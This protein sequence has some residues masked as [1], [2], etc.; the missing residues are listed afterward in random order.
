VRFG[1]SDKIQ[2]ISTVK[3]LESIEECLPRP[4]KH[5]IP[6]WFKD[7]PSSNS[8]SIK[9]CPAL[10]DYFSQGYIIPMWCDVRMSVEKNGNWNWNTSVGKFSWTSHSNDQLINHTDAS[11][12]G[13]DGQFIFKA[14]SPWQI[15]TPPG[16]SVLQLPLFYHFNKEWSVLPGIIDTDIY[17]ETNQQV[18]YHA[19]GK[20][21]KI[22]RG[23][24]FVLYVPFKRSNKLKHSISYTT[25]KNKLKTDQ[26]KLEINTKF[27]P[28]GWYRNKQRKRDKG[29][30]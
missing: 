6:Q 23:D 30:L 2:F 1:K 28:T 12:N 14:D 4:A 25:E 24:P 8:M 26:Y 21:I 17:H 16:W 11:F 13:V 19:N 20:E 29:L 9:N 27:P 10:P 3:G 5:F 18:L 15:I 22:K 7:I